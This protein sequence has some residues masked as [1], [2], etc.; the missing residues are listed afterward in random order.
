MTV[1]IKAIKDRLD[2]HNDR[3]G[4][5]DPVTHRTFGIVVSIADVEELLA[6]YEAAQ[7]W[8][9]HVPSCREDRLDRDHDLVEALVKARGK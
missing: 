9:E 2:A 6:V 4:T 8:W 3:F 5:H 1:N 7:L